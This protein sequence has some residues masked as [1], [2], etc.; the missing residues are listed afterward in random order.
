MSMITP[1]ASVKI[2][3][4]LPVSLR[5]FVNVSSRF[6]ADWIASSSIPDLS[7][8]FCARFSISAAVTFAASPVD[9]STARVCL[10]A[11]SASSNSRNAFFARQPQPAPPRRRRHTAAAS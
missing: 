7:D 5:T 11:F 6:S 9:F 1:V 2:L 10:V 3:L 4:P 8:S